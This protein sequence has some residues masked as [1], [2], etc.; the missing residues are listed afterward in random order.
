MKSVHLYISGI[1]QGV[2][3][4]Y[5]TRREALSLGLSG[6]VRNLSDGRVE[7][8]AEGDPEKVDAF[9]KWCRRGPD[10]AEVVSV[11]VSESEPEGLKGFD[12]KVLTA[13]FTP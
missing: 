4:R 1:V 8:V 2:S 3:F 5:W 7:A 11:E 13:V 9:V 6:W 12:V 10:L